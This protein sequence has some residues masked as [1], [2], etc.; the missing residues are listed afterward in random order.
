YLQATQEA[1]VRKKSVLI[2]VPEIALTHQLIEQLRRRF[3]TKVTVLH[4]AQLSSEQWSEWQR[5]AHGEATVVVGVRSAVFAPLSNIGLIVVDEEHDGAYKQEE[6]VRYNARDLA[7][8]RGKISSCAVILGS[9]TPSLESYVH[10]RNQQY[11]LVELP[12]RVT[13]QPLPSVE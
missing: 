10:S 13:V 1:L 11:T 6:G 2:L 7:I 12:E 8:V 9:A 5:I 4:S 3:G